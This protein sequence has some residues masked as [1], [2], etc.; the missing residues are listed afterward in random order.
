M[1]V[2]PERKIERLLSLMVKNINMMMPLRLNKRITGK[3][4]ICKL[5]LKE[6]IKTKANEC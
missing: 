2:I 6:K 3:D 5:L 1:L 4:L